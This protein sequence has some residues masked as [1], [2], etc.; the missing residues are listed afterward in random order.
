[1]KVSTKAMTTRLHAEIRDNLRQAME[2]A[3]DIKNTDD[4]FSDEI[5]II[6][7]SFSDLQWMLEGLED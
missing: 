3:S 4:N 6:R 1:M 2:A 5:A 7:K